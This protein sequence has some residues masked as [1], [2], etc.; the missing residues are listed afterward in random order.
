MASDFTRSLTLVLGW[1]YGRARESWSQNIMINDSAP[2]RR[3]RLFIVA[4][5]A[6]FTGGAAFSIRAGT[7]VHMRTEYLDPLDKLNAGEMLGAALGDSRDVADSLSALANA[8]R[9]TGAS[10]EAESVARQARDLT[11]K[12]LPR[13]SEPVA[14]ANR[15]LGAA[16]CAQGMLTA[17]LDFLHDSEAFF[18]AHPKVEPRSAAITRSAS[19]YS[20]AAADRS[21]GSWRRGMASGYGTGRGRTT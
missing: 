5:L 10:R 19:R 4:L 9:H 17:G 8:L 6:L 16:L 1:L 14:V 21:R 11:L 7:A 13:E 12:L 18:S 2:L 15:E 20:W 3:G